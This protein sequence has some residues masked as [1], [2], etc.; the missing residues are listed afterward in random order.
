MMDV[1]RDERNI[2]ITT[3]HEPNEVTVCI[4]DSGEGINPEIIDSIFEPLATWKPGGTGMG[5]A[6]SNSIVIAHGGRMK[7]EN[8]PEGGA[9][10]CFSLP[11]IKE[12]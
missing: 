10:V 2:T 11:V 6:I 1:D 7:A 9:C 3:S 12:S 4:M 8:Q 5:L